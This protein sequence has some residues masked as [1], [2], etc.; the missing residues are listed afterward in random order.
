MSMFDPTAMNRRRRR[1][2]R[3]IGYANVSI[4]PLDKLTEKLLY[5]MTSHFDRV[6]RR[7]SVG[8]L[9]SHTVAGSNEKGKGR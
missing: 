2:L 4:I 1:E 9:G 8:Q 5:L 3:R 6:Y 7:T